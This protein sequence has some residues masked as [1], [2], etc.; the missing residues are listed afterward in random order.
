MENNQVIAK[1]VT[2]ALMANL[3]KAIEQSGMTQVDLAEATG[4]PQ[5]S[6]SRALTEGYVPNFET[7]IRLSVAIGAEVVLIPKR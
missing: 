4:M 5:P 3:K 1:T 2:L 7:F 6:I